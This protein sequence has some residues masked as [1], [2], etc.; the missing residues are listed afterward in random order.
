MKQKIL[1]VIISLFAATQYIVA[2]NKPYVFNQIFSIT[3]SDLLELR[4]DNDAYTHFLK[5]TLNYDAN[6]EIV[7]QQKALSIKE[8]CALSRY[9]RIMMQ[10]YT[11]DE[12]SFPTA[13]DNN[14]SSDDLQ[15]LIDACDN[16]LAPGQNYVN[17]PIVDIKE[18]SNGCTFVQLS[19]IR[20]G[21]SGNVSVRICY[22]FNYKYAVKAIFSYRNSEL[23]IWEKP[24]DEAINSFFWLNPYTS[25]I[26]V[27]TNG[28]QY[29]D[30]SSSSDKINLY[31]GILIGIIIMSIL[32]VVYSLIKS[33]K[34]KR[35][36]KLLEQEISDI[37]HLI[38]NGKIVSAHNKI[39]AI[40]GYKET[41]PD[42]ISQLGRC[43]EALRNRTENIDKHINTII[44]HKCPE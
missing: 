32:F 29:N 4:Q 22:F 41:T 20:S 3:I 26:Y 42:L 37:T 7:F 27:D 33:N 16:E 10:V 17:K 44:D 14:F 25:S 35:L 12:M 11:D 38:D 34:R 8:S 23:D 1:I 18:N 31:V 6:S 13:D 43:E 5:D 24:L 21:Y 28:E 2:A 30:L 40:R 39:V 9:C 15:E 19:Y 36:I